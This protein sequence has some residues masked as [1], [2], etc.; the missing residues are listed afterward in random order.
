MPSRKATKKSR[1]LR[2]TRGRGRRRT[3]RGGN[4]LLLAQQVCNEIKAAKDIK[5]ATTAYRKGALKLHPDKGGNEEA[6]KVLQR[7]Y[8]AKKSPKAPQPAP[9]PAPAPAPSPATHQGTGQANLYVYFYRN[10]EPVDFNTLSE[11][12]QLKVRGAV[13][14]TFLEIQGTF[15]IVKA[16]VDYLKNLKNGVEIPIYTGDITLKLSGDPIGGRRKSRR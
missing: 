9:A 4:D 5:S 11:Y 7:C 6:F 8:E 13:V 3:Q 15:G 2:K 10:N 16:P 12:E 1:K 14:Y